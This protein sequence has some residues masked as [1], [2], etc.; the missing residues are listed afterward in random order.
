MATQDIVVEL[1]TKLSVD[2]INP[3][4]EETKSFSYGLKLSDGS[5]N[6]PFVVYFSSKH[7]QLNMSRYPDHNAIFHID[8]TYKLIKKRFPVLVFGRSDLIKKF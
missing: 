1:L 8:G 4:D 5:D 7:L 2:L 3:D 6:D